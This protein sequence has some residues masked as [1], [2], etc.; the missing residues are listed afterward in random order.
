[1]LEEIII[2]YQDLPRGEASAI[3]HVYTKRKE[4][5]K[6]P[7]VTYFDSVLDLADPEALQHYVRI[8]QERPVT[9]SQSFGTRRTNQSVNQHFKVESPKG[10]T[11]GGIFHRIHSSC[12]QGLTEADLDNSITKLRAY[13]NSTTFYDAIKSMVQ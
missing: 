8:K 13:V 5:A 1:M 4:D 10:L 11:E 7:N 9:T 2:N 6:E 12:S 3:D